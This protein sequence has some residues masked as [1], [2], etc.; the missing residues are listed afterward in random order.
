MDS[1]NGVASCKRSNRR[2]LG[3]VFESKPIKRG[4]KSPFQQQKYSLEL[5]KLHPNNNVFPNH[6]QQHLHYGTH[7]LKP[8]YFQEI[9]QHGSSTNH[10]KEKRRLVKTVPQDAEGIGNNDR[11]TKIG[12]GHQEIGRRS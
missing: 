8:I 6:K 1:R 10:E 9:E 2:L 12:E 7:I 5:P 4:S 3:K 11:H